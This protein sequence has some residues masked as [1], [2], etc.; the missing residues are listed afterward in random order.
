MVA[1]SADIIIAEGRK[2]T[3]NLITGGTN[4]TVQG[5][6]SVVAGLIYAP[7]AKSNS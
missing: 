4:V 7:S 1:K 2:F 6:G 5:G 3:G